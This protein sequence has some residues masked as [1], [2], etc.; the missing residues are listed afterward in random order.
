VFV[1]SVVI[2][3]LA[4]GKTF[5]QGAAAMNQRILLF[6]LIFPIMALILVP[7][8]V[9]RGDGEVDLGFSSDGYDL[10]TT[11]FLTNT[12]GP[13]PTPTA[14]VPYKEI[15]DMYL[16]S[17][18]PDLA[19]VYYIKALENDPEDLH[20]LND[21]QAA[22]NALN[23]DP[24]IEIA[25]ELFN[26]QR[27][28]EAFVLYSKIL[29]DNSSNLRSQ[30]GAIKAAQITSGRFRL[31]LLDV[32]QEGLPKLIVSTIELILNAVPWLFI[33]GS[34]YLGAK[35]V[36]N[37]R[38]KKLYRDPNKLLEFVILPFD[39][40]VTT[41]GTKGIEQAVRMQIADWL[42]KQKALVSL[43]NQEINVSQIDLPDIGAPITK[44]ANWFSSI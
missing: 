17:K 27:Y 16:N 41:E 7:L 39:N 43:K 1:P 21:L 31:A 29:E 13:E 25:D 30:Q 22:L 38:T 23:Y 2:E 14:K 35:L 18:K 37:I 44:L 12:M 8:S 24:R 20:L 6:P 33:L 10:K 36:Q 5:K 3:N 19:A 34:I 11:A 28:E 26:Q 40:A 42:L 15:G 4:D 9:D 32:Y